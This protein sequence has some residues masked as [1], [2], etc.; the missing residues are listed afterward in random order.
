MATCC[1][2]L[3]CGGGRCFLGRAAGGL[4]DGELGQ[5]KGC[6]LRIYGIG[7]LGVILFKEIKILLFI[8]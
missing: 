4:A 5:Q 3:R 7:I 8:H 2:R 6:T 1:C